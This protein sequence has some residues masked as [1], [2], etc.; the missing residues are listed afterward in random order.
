MIGLLS[1]L[2][3]FNGRWK[4]FFPGAY[5]I[6]QSNLGLTYGGTLLDGGGAGPVL[7]FTGALTGSPVP[8]WVKCTLGGARGTWTYNI[9][10]DGLGTTVAMSGTSTASAIPLTGAGTG[11]SLN[12]AAG[13]AALNNIWKATSAGLADQSGNGHNYSQ[14]AAGKQPII[15][16]GL[17]GKPGLLFDGID[18]ELKST[19]PTLPAPGTTP[20]YQFAVFRQITWATNHFIFSDTGLQAKVFQAVSTPL[21]FSRTLNTGP[22]NAGAAINA[23]VELEIARANSASDTF[24]LGSTTATA[25]QGNTGGGATMCIASTGGAN[26]ANVELLALAYTPVLPNWVNV[27]KAVPLLYGAG[28]VLL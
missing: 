1:T 12:I 11:A 16:I 22:S 28:N 24:K 13:T 3:G 23:W 6:V 27:R 17:N 5:Q 15:T 14:A 18:D 8:I 4:T 19:G 26:Y 20:Y 9:Y 2:T 7:T 10:Y 25:S 21:I